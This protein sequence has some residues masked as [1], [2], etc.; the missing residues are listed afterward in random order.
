M[1]ADNPQSLGSRAHQRMSRINRRISVLPVPT[2]SNFSKRIHG[3]TWQAYP[4]GLGKFMPISHRTHQ[5]LIMVCFSRS[6]GPIS[7]AVQKGSAR[8][9]QELLYTNLRTSFCNHYR[10]N[11]QLCPLDIVSGKFIFCDRVGITA[12]ELI[13]FFWIYV[14]VAIIVAFTVLTIWFSSP[15]NPTAAMTPAWAFPVFPLLLTGVVTFNVLRIVPLTDP[16]AVSIFVTGLFMFG[17]GAFMCIF[18]L[19]I[20]LLRIM[21]TGFL[22]GHQANG[23][24]IA[25]GPPVRPSFC[26]SHWSYTNLDGSV[27]LISYYHRF[28]QGFSALVLFNMGK[29]ASKL[30]PIHSLISPNAGEIVFGELLCLSQV[31]FFSSEDQ[32]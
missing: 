20:F 29:I 6:S 23:A 19:A 26:S 15:R 1:T 11:C 28:L 8:S 13:V 31:I 14:T 21:T 16:R 30:F 2:V 22:D 32:N 12:D 24:F 25:A 4:V 18:Y 27:Y 5:L 17:A 10:W 7:Q 9:K 3:I